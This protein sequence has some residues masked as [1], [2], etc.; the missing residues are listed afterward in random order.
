MMIFTYIGT[1]ATFGFLLSYML[2]VIAA[3]FFLK[4]RN[5]MKISHIILSVV[6]FGILL[7]PFIGSVYPL[8]AFPFILFPFI[9]L[10][11]VI[12]SI[13]WYAYKTR[14]S[15]NTDFSVDLES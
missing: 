12:F 4:K 10:A 5:E 2:V 11:W 3:P 7:I 1:I 13:L 14:K 9:F 15:A 8:P 6:T